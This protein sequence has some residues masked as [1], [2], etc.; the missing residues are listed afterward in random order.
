MASE[1]QMRDTERMQLS[2]SP[3][4]T[5]GLTEVYGFVLWMTTFVIYVVFILWAYLPEE[6]L[7]SMGVTYY[8]SKSVSSF[9]SASASLPVLLLVSD[10]MCVCVCVCVYVCMQ[11]VGPCSSF[12]LRHA[13]R[14]CPGAL[15]WLQ[16]VPHQSS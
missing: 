3:P 8:P 2:L 15:C 14:V 12:L 16:H 4:S 7:V 9:S 10:F 6:V 13:A 1:M 11:M 5:T